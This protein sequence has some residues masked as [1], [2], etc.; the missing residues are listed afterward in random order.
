VTTSPIRAADGSIIGVSALGRDVTDALKSADAMR[1]SEARKS[2]I[3]AGA[4]DAVIT[5]DHTGQVLEANPAMTATQ[6]AGGQ[7]GGVR[8]GRVEHDAVAVGD[9][10]EQVAAG[11]NGPVALAGVQREGGQ[12]GEHRDVAGAGR[13]E[14]R[15][16]RAAARAGDPLDVEGGGLEGGR[17]LGAHRVPP[18]ACAIWVSTST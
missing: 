2:A 10:L 16:G 8:A 4:L 3:L 13:P 9:Q 7:D 5:I 14:R 12:R 11:G 17:Q 6:G 1:E 18:A 15:D